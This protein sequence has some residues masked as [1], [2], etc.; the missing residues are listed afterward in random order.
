MH[1]IFYD[2]VHDEIVVPVALGG[3][4]LTLPGDAAGD[5]PPRATGTTISSCFGS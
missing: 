5:A 2:H 4:I 1:G 3:A